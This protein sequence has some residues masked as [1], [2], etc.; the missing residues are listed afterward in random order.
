MD[1]TKTLLA[2]DFDVW[3]SD[4]SSGDLHRKIS[5][6]LFGRE[7]VYLSRTSEGNPPLIQEEIRWIIFILDTSSPFTYMSA[8]CFKA[9]GITEQLLNVNPSARFLINKQALNINL[10][11][12]KSHFGDVNVLGQ[13]LLRAFNATLNVN[14]ETSL[15]TIDFQPQQQR[16]LTENN[17]AAATTTV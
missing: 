16:R 1:T 14:Y 12:K 11:P 10:S 5:L 17:N 6:Q 7:G 15:A 8:E 4:V 13:D 9:F 2:E 3:L